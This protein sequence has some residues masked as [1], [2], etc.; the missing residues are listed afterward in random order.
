MKELDEIGNDQCNDGRCKPELCCD[1]WLSDNAR[2]HM[3]RSCN[4]NPAP[5]PASYHGY[6]SIRSARLLSKHWVVVF[7]PES[8]LMNSIA[9]AM[10]RMPCK[11]DASGH[12][13]ESIQTVATCTQ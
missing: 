10:Y 12:L 7:A 13:L 3:S 8:M 1:S 4:P 2:A 9:K 6:S 11:P 5:G